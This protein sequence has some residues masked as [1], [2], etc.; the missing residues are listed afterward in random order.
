MVHQ[1]HAAV[2]QWYKSSSPA[3]SNHEVCLRLQRWP[4]QAW[5]PT[6][7]FFVAKLPCEGWDKPQD[8][9]E[10]HGAE[11]VAMILMP[12]GYN[13]AAQIRGQ[14]QTRT[15]TACLMLNVAEAAKRTCHVRKPGCIVTVDFQQMRYFSLFSA[16]PVARSM[17]T[18]PGPMASLQEIESW[19]YVR[20]KASTKHRRR[21]H[22]RTNAILEFVY[23]RRLHAR[24]VQV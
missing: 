22:T 5:S 10:A 4:V 7:G 6:T 8:N 12:C 13:T 23:L 2:H 17:A 14:P 1:K 18:E 20:A 21:E 3:W 9:C 19:K 16:S 15:S 24:G 11:Q